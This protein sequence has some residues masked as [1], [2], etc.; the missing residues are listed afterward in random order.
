VGDGHFGG[1]VRRN[2]GGAGGVRGGTSAREGTII[3]FCFGLRL[4]TCWQG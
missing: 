1:L 4:T 3:A 2:E